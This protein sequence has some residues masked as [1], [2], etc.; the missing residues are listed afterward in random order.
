MYKIQVMGLIRMQKE[1]GSVS[2]PTDAAVKGV[3]TDFRKARLGGGKKSQKNYLNV[4]GVE[5][6]RRY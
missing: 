1:R 2:C 3:K 4:I 5:M 6:K